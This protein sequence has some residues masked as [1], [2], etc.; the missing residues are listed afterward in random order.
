MKG[1]IPYRS[2]DPFLGWLPLLVLAGVVLTSCGGPRESPHDVNVVLVTFDTIRGDH[3]S[4]LGYALPTTPNLDELCEQ[5][6]SFHR[7]YATSS[8]TAPSH[9]SL[10]TGLLPSQHGCHMAPWEEDEQILPLSSENM[11]LA[12][13]LSESGWATAGFIGGPAIAGGIGF[14]RG[15]DLYD[16][17]WVG[18]QRLGG[19]TNEKVF[20]WLSK[21]NR[22][23]FLFVNYFDAHGPYEP[24]PSLTYPFGE[25]PEAVEPYQSFSPGTAKRQKKTMPTDPEEIRHIV[26][27]YDQEIFATDHFLGRLIK[28]LKELGKWDRTLLVVTGDH[29][30]AFSDQVGAEV[31]WGHGH[32]PGRVQSHVPLVLRLPGDVRAGEVVTRTVS[33]QDLFPTLCD[34]LSLPVPSN[35][36]GRS[37]LLPITDGAAMAEKFFPGRY[38]NTFFRDDFMVRS[39]EEISSGHVRE[40]MHDLSDPTGKKLIPIARIDDPEVKMSDEDRARAREVARALLS[41]RAAHKKMRG[42]VSPQFEPGDLEGTKLSEETRR[43]LGA[44]GYLESE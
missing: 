43:K 1:R 16:D 10:F 44:L 3:I 29:G 22:P 7:S 33:N 40:T 25:K 21:V 31:F 37:L 35:V 23:F 17:D 8:W 15:F 4:H 11:T 6:I 34:F 39:L 30:E 13:L 14:S 26:E 9:G 12:E 27:R 2:V 36:R 20:A 42:G 41:A 32:M 5:G 38:G 18:P 19:A 24:D 28:R